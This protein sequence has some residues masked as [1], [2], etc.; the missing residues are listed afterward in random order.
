MAR[1]AFPP[2]AIL[3]AIATVVAAVTLTAGP[4]SARPSA[5]G[6]AA[7]PRS[8]TP[9]CRASDLRISAPAAIQ[10]DPAE[11]MGKLAWNLVFSNTARS[12]CSLRGWPRLVVQTAAGKTVATRISDVGYSNL[13]V[14][15]DAQIIL[16]PGQSAVVTVT[17]S[18]APSGC[19]SKWM[20]RLTLPGADDPVTVRQP[21]GSFVPCVGGQL[22]LSPF[23]A[24]QTLTHEIKELKVSAAPPPFSATTAA[25]P[26]ACKTATLRAQITST[27]SGNGGTIVQLRLSNAGST[28]V[29]PQSWPTVQVHEASGPS[30][31]AKILP[32]AATLQAERSLLTTYTRGTAQSTVLTLQHGGS[33]S[34]ALLA[35]GTPTRACHRLTSVTVYPAAVALGAGRAVHAAVPVSICGSPRILSYLPSRPGGATMA[36]ARGAL[37]EVRADTAGTAN[38]SSNGYYYGT[39]SSAPDGCGKGPYT[40]PA[41][42]CSN[43]THGYYGEYIGE[44]GSYMNW[45]GCTTSGLNW[46]QANY[47]MAN[48]NL[49]NYQIGLGAAGYWFAAGPGRDPNYN[50]TTSEATA[51]GAAQA[52]QV[53]S[54]LSGVF[55][56]FRYIF[57]D[58]ENNGTAPDGNGWNTVW[59]GPCGSKIK[60]EYIA[61]EV[62]YATFSG[63]RNY[64]DIH[65]TYLAGV[66]SAG[67]NSYGSWA[68]IF[69]GGKIHHTAEWTFINEQTSLKFPSGFST[70]TVSADWF[71]SA[72]AACHLMWQ[73][74][75][76]NGDLN[77]YGDF[78]QALAANDANKSC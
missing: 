14:V 21:A 28:C 36:I 47:N 53:I 7:S 72:P 19:V 31:V 46:V 22:G 2:R 77:G 29:L 63:F 45:K 8:D 68:G 56:N 15:P 23:Y 48:D 70:G 65:S 25:E 67:G 73:W 42:F 76:G 43:G 33:V 39:D 20:L 75:G 6:P 37:D 44:M 50:G 55:F 69:G 38:G 59:N 66:Y 51:W 4:A 35:A 64:L 10:G 61:P 71:A 41:G 9:D 57:M 78:D 49:V 74:S 60:A 24:E 16:R 27:A 32:D 13:A 62:D 40:E 3:W 5:P 26:P 58:I 30:L 12:A 52:K 34:I 11:G 1:R 17:S 54:H 18:T